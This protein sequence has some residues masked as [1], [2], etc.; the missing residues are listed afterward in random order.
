MSSHRAR[1]AACLLG[2][3]PA[4]SAAHCDL[5]I[6][7]T[8]PGGAFAAWHAAE[9]GR[10]VCVFELGDRP[11]G[12][13]HS[14]R[15]MGPRRDLVV[16]AG[17]YRFAPKEVCE[18]MGPNASWCI[19]TPI[20]AASV[21][22]LGL[23]AGVYD[24]NPWNWDYK[25]RKLIDKH[26]HNVGYLTLVESM[27]ERAAARGAEL[28]FSTEVTGLAGKG[29]SSS[30]ELKLAEGGSVEASA[31]LLN[32][33]QKPLLKLLRHSG[34]PFVDMYS[35]PLYDP[36]SFPIMKLYVHYEDAWWRNYLNLTSG[37]FFNENP[38]GSSSSVIHMHAVPDQGP[39]PLM[40][41]YHDGDVRCDGPGGRCRGFLQAFYSGGVALDFYKAYHP[42]NG[43]AA[44]RLLPSSAEH[45]QLLASVH[46]ALLE[47]HRK[48]LD[49]VNATALVAG[50]APDS[51]LLSIWAEGVS[52]INGGCHVPKSG[53]NPSP[54]GL[55]AAALRP[56]G[57]WPV[58]VANEAYGPVPC[59]AEG[60]LNMSS[61]ALQALGVP[62]PAWLDAEVGRQ[63]TQRGHIPP[64]PTDPFL[65]MDRSRH[66]S[67]RAARS[68]EHS[69]VI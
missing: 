16:E 3:L 8:G 47:L 25:M 2:F 37:P 19:R 29:D 9:A 48:A 23:S 35:A 66:A 56:F 33:P 62:R 41:Q 26:G 10:H 1:L 24:P 53:S 42:L 63:V 38:S 30:V 46:K 65:F 67:Q 44:V 58:F 18:P 54:E 69:V 45:R 34:P 4:A 22:E 60:S 7:G 28:H 51:G 61:A 68:E 20:T 64:P 13:I 27:L 21:K 31:V 43:E 5:A 11:G 49:A 6:V 40:G 36:V 52:G 50:M 14:L 57:K 15:G 17:A 59:F 39:A 12:R 55:P 32:I